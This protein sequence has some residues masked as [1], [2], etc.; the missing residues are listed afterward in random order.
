MIPKIILNDL[1]KDKSIIDA[2]IIDFPYTFGNTDFW[3]ELLMD[4]ALQ[5]IIT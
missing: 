2:C 4:L 3:L 1:T 5:K